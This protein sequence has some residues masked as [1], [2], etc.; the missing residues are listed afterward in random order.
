MW[1]NEHRQILL[2]FVSF[3]VLLLR[4]WPCFWWV[5]RSDDGYVERVSSSLEH[6]DPLS[7]T[8]EYWVR[9]RV[10]LIVTVTCTYLP[11]AFPW[12]CDLLSDGR[13]APRWWLQRSC[14]ARGGA[15]TSYRSGTAGWGMWPRCAC[16]G[17]SGP[18]PGEQR[19]ERPRPES[20]AHR[21]MTARRLQDNKHIL[22][23]W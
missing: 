4:L 23:C 19:P 1:Y 14:V 5:V 21:R 20:V 3:W 8:C 7:T 18:G 11:S 12:G 16:W 9:R 22:Q 6:T 17:T 15:A 10:E 13:T 2:K